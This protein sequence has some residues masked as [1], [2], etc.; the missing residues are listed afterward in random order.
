MANFELD[1]A[2]WLPQG[3]QIIDGGAA[4][5]PR[6]FYNALVP[7]PRCHSNIC[8]AVLILP[9]PPLDEEHWRN[10]VW[11]FVVHNL[12]GAVDDF[13]PSLFGL[14][15]LC[16]RS[17]VAQAAL[18]D[19]GPFQLQD[20]VFVYFIPHDDRDNHRAM[21]GFCNGWLM[22]LGLP[23]DYRNEYDIASAVGTFGKYHHW[24]QDDEVLDRTLVY[25]SFPSPV[26]V[27]RDV[28]FGNFANIGGV[29]E[30]WTAPYYILT[31]DFANGFPAEEDQ[32]LPDG[33]PHP[34]PGHMHPGD[35]NFVVPQF[36][37]LGWNE[38]VHQPQVQDHDFFQPEP[39]VDNQQN[40][41]AAVQNAEIEEDSVEEDV[42]SSIV[43]YASDSSN[44]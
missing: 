8:T 30:S 34:L 17:A 15:F 13:Q 41:Q 21:Q 32:M 27:P 42:H 29:R 26:L 39:V 36:P 3:H 1:P 6:T 40:P 14:G 33:N 4:R 5:L 18:L 22:F 19:H 23:L 37:E 20:G 24:H 35:N 2:R 28:V 44:D 25:A 9:L 12:H 38:V 43:P 11:N 16:L 31:A 7:P 10:Q